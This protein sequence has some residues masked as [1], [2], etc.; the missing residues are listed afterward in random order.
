MTELTTNQIIKII[1]AVL[2][3]VIVAVAVY[4]SFSNYI[5]PYFK[6]FGIEPPDLTSQYYKE[7]LKEENLVG[8]VEIEREN[9]IRICGSPTNYYF[10]KDS[11]VIKKDIV[12]NDGA[13]YED[14]WSRI[15]FDPKVGETGKDRK[16]IILNE[17]LNDDG[18]ILKKIEGAERIGNEVRKIGG[19][20]ESG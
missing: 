14:I 1:I 6:G 11:P 3:F 4:W 7:L 16:I 19:C 8:F 2:V 12:T 18:G 10:V 20:E 9:K 13:W 15:K 5:I 17:Y